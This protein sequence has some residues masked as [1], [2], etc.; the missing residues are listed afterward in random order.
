MTNRLHNISAALTDRGLSEK[1]PQNEDSF[2]EMS[3]LGV[4][5]VADGVGGAEGG[6][7]ASQ[8]AMEMLGEAIANKPAGVDGEEILKTAIESANSAIYQTAQQLSKLSSMATTIVA[9][10][11]A[12][13]IA[14]IGHVGDSRLYRVD[15]NGNLHRETEDH[16]M[17]ADEVRA[18]RMTVE[19]AE[20]HPSKNVISRALGAELTVEADLKTIL[21]DPE[22]TFLLCSDGITRH[23]SDDEIKNVLLSGNEPSQICE[24]L[25]SLVYA[26]GAEDN[27]TA[28][29]VRCFSDTRQNEIATGPLSEEEDTLATARNYSE[30]IEVDEP[31]T[32]RTDPEPQGNVDRIGMF[33]AYEIGTEKS[34]AGSLSGIVT[35]A[36]M[37][38][39]GSLI[40]LGV[41]HF[42]L[43][44]TPKDPLPQLSEMKSD[45]I[46]ITS[47][48]KLRRTVDNDPASYLKE[49]PPARDAEDFYLQGRAHLLIGDYVKAR[50]ALLEAQKN[51][52]ASDPSNSKVLASDI[53]AALV[54]A[55]DADLQRR[56]RGEIENSLKNQP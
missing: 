33:S 40:G 8:M 43:V 49:V 37:L 18:G 47:F 56:F 10:H 7:V 19:Q 13:N 20:N 30:Q 31:T 50:T 46:A 9:L 39:L 5:A 55:N 17:V 1:R 32:V 27:L 42:L 35:S 24:R 26:R 38:L 6:E 23:V 44:T 36:G 2:L 22:T 48:E 54:I 45:N 15:P 16:S 21:V 41:Y 29:V 4:F 14:T 3:H 34:Y 28:V 12:D 11:I 53:A 25:K 51:L 52:A